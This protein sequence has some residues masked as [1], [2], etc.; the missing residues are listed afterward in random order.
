MIVP[1]GSFWTSHIPSWGSW[2]REERNVTIVCWVQ[3]AYSCVHCCTLRTIRY[4]SVSSS[5]L[6]LPEEEDSLDTEEISSCALDESPKWLLFL[7]LIETEEG[8]LWW[9]WRES[10]AFDGESTRFFCTSEARTF[11]GWGGNHYSGMAECV[12][13]AATR[14]CHQRG[15]W[16]KTD[17]VTVDLVLFF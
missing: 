5:L 17:G 7:S 4:R 10:H 2:R 15:C 3:H 12:A 14:R 16:P 13:M 6:L 11:E 9:W 1:G 8:E